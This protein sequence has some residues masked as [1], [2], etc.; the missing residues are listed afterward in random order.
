M[1]P[2]CGKPLAVKQSR[3][4][5]FIACTGYPDCK[6]TKPIIKTVGVKCPQCGNDIIVRRSKKGKLFYGCMGYPNCNQVFWDKPVEEKCP[7]CG[8]LL[9]QK[10]KKLVCSNAECKFSKANE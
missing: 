7:K 5:E 1:C 3:F 10:G 6:Y 8:S 9:T 4:G 2:E